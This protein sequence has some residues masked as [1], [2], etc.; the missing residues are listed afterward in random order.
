M[1]DRI[2]LG[3]LLVLLPA[4]AREEPP[5]G[6]LPDNR[7][8]EVTGIRPAD[9]AVVPDLDGALKI[10]FNEPIQENRSV[11]RDL[12]ASPADRYRVG[13]GFSEIRIRP[14]EGG[15]RPGAV[16]LFR[17]STPISDI[18]GNRSERPIDVV[19]STG[20]P[21][22]GTRVEGTIRERV[23]GDRVRGGRVLF[24]RVGGDSVPY[25]VVQDT[26]DRFEMRALPPDEYRAWA[27]RD[28]NANMRL[29]KRLEPYDSAT[30]TLEDSSSRA[31]VAFEIV[32]PDTT[33]PI[34][35]SASARDSLLVELRFDDPLEPRQELEAR[36]VV[37]RDTARDVRWPVR[38]VALTEAGVRPPG[39][40]ATGV[41]AGDTAG[42]APTDTARGVP[43]DT[44]AA[45][46]AGAAADPTAGARP[47]PGAR[48]RVGPVGAGGGATAGASDTLPRPSRSLFVRLGRA[49]EPGS[50]YAVE[51]DSFMNLRRLYGGGDTT[52][53]YEPA[54]SADSVTGSDTVPP[55]DAPSPADTVPD[56]ATERPHRE[57]DGRPAPGAGA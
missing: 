42:V 11:Q 44:A 48:A 1:R 14:Q 39:E 45:D 10:R 12:R 4:C 28:L 17:V 32:E 56:A 21:I 6:A 23:T 8:P 53:V 52:F 15:W 55:P 3:A 18:M 22:T 5:P 9:G 57:R 54:G 50:V 35:A 41:P 49:L 13:F 51:A 43:P 27:F 37:I 20:P 16:Y 47:D 29:E 38:A 31:S 34:L 33:P 19:F 7:P 36:R 2:L 25:S 24:L 46:T 40:D 26:A 30:F